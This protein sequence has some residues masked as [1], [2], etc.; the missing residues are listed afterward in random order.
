MSTSL[1]L[2]PG[3]FTILPRGAASALSRAARRA[4]EALLWEDTDYGAGE[5]RATDR[6]L[7]AAMGCS[8]RTAQRAVCDLCA[9]TIR[10]ADGVLRAIMDRRR[11]YGPREVA[12][13]R[14]RVIAPEVVPVPAEESPAAAVGAPGEGERIRRRFSDQVHSRRT[15]RADPIPNVPAIE[16]LTPEQLEAGRR[17]AE[18]GRHVPVVQTPEETEQARRLGSALRAWLRAGSPGDF[19]AWR[20]LHPEATPP[21]EVLSRRRE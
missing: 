20:Q 21:L 12:G 2:R 5:S 6:E 13:R 15:R 9:A 4:L 8:L 11:H 16:P 19:E 18:A 1:V 7:A 10:G 3:P 17:A 14:L